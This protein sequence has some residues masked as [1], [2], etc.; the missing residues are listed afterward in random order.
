MLPKRPFCKV[1]VGSEC[2]QTPYPESIPDGHSQVSRNRTL[3][4][5]YPSKCRS[6]TSVNWLHK[7]VVLIA[8]GIYH[9]CG[10]YLP[11]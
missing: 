1:D 9:Y 4:S 8:P 7:N 11:K 2:S 10:R 3:A 6:P 5:H